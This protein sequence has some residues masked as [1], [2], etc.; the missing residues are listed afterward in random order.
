MAIVGF[1]PPARGKAVNDAEAIETLYRYLFNLSEKLNIALSKVGSGTNATDQVA[2]GPI[3]MISN[4]SIRLAVVS[5]VKTDYIEVLEDH[6]TI[7]T[8]GIFDVQSGKF[9]VVTDDFTL[10]LVKAGGNEVVIDIDDDGGT[11]FKAVHAGNLREAVL[12]RVHFVGAA[13]I[14][15]MRGLADYL[16]R[17]DCRDV[18]YTMDSDEYGAVTLDGY[19]GALHIYAEGHRLPQ[20]TL[21]EGFAARTC[22]QDALLTQNAAEQYCVEQHGGVL[23]LRDCW[24]MAAD[25]GLYVD[26]CGELRWNQ[27]R[28]GIELTRVE[29]DPWLMV[30]DGGTA[31]LGGVIPYGGIHVGGGWVTNTGTPGGGE[32]PEEDPTQTIEGACAL[33]TYSGANGWSEGTAIQGY[34]K[35]GRLHGG[36]IDP[37]AVLAQ[38]PEGETVSAYLSLH[39]A[40]GAGYNTVLNTQ[41]SASNAE[42]G[43]DSPEI[44]MGGT[45]AQLAAWDGV[46]SHD[47]TGLIT[48]IRAGNFKNI[49]ITV[50]EMTAEGGKETSANYAVIDAATLTV[51]INTGGGS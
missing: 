25:R 9:Q 8:D 12:D 16:K 11:T 37:S 15:G 51:T 34:S 47:V 39:R 13:S 32:E 4:K 7:M 14:G 5:G 31:Y 45:A 35:S 3:N 2:Q 28:P 1:E 41:I 17:T 40:T 36:F 33:F 19:S 43:G 23:S 48:E 26:G 27:S 10:S 49:C 46:S 29:I 50:F 22:I 42:Y 20:L 38:L 18:A 30:V 44:T 24:L 6:V 21:T